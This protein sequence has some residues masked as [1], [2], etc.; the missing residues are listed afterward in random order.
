[1]VGAL[2]DPIIVYDSPWKETLP[3]WIKGEIKTQ[4]ILQLAVAQQDESQRDVATDAE[5]LAYMY[6]LTLERPIG[7]DWTKI[8]LYLGTRV[9]SKNMPDDIREDRLTDYQ[10]QKLIDLKRWI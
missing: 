10:M 8:Y 3:E 2:A 4:R 7:S 9:M 6:P 5:A 1:M